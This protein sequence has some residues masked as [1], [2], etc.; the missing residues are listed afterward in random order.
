[1][2]LFKFDQKELLTAN[3]VAEALNVSRLTV[4]RLGRNGDI[5]V[6]KVADT[7]RYVKQSVIDYIEN[8]N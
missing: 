4:Y 7:N 1:M 2:K 3:E 5:K 6:Y 8:Q